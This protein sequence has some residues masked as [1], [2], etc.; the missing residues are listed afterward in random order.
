MNE[1]EKFQD[2]SPERIME[3]GHR[4]MG[5]KGLSASFPVASLPEHR[6]SGRIFFSSPMFFLDSVDTGQQAIW[7]DGSTAA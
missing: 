3:K 6:I 4:I 1:N 5:F 7:L 2:A